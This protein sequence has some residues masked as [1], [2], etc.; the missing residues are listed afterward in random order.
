[1]GNHPEKKPIRVLILLTNLSVSNGVSSFIM[2]YYRKLDDSIIKMDFAVL[3]DRPSPYIQEVK[4][5]GSK[6][7]VLPPVN[8]MNQHIRKCMQILDAGNYDI[9]HDNSLILTI[10]MMLCAM[11]KRVPVRI[12]HSHSAKVGFTRAKE[13]R[14][15]VFLP[16]LK[17]TA[18][19]YVA[20]SEVAGWGIFGKRDFKV[21]YNVI[22][23]DRFTF[24]IEKRN[25]LRTKMGVQDSFIVGSVGRI[26]DEKNPFFAMDVFKLIAKKEPSARYWWIGSGT[27]DEQLLDY[28]KKLEIE[29]RVSFLG[30]RS[31]VA[32]LYQA[33]D[34]FF[35]PSK[36]EGLPITVIEAQAMGLRCVIS[37]AITREV[38]YTDF[39]RWVSL[40]KE[41]Q[42]WVEAIIE[43][44][45]ERRI[46][47]SSKESSSRFS[48]KEAGQKV[49]SLYMSF[50]HS[51]S[52]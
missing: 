25:Q 4:A 2:N 22:D 3:Y 5:K 1:M 10:P 17:L 47:L 16:L 26:S 6:V 24:D 40:E 42:S 38:E 49:Y 7:F 21:L 43:C 11:V 13:I 19:H 8:K 41:K 51:K 29:D 33:I 28:V 32:D 48:A 34:C 18:T 50:L 46:G 20:C 12:L 31:D 14:N 15:K 27:L 52:E 39:I 45:K 44:S 35:M 9:I 30:I 37:D 36:F 23:F